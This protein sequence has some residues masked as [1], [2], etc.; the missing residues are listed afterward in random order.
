MTPVLSTSKTLKAYHGKPTLKQALLKELAAHRKADQLIKGTYWDGGKGC[1]VG[2]TID[3]LARIE[4]LADLERGNHALYER[5]LGIPEPLARIED[6]IFEGLPNALAQR[7]PEQFSAAIRPGADLSMVWVKF[8]HNLLTAKTGGVQRQIARRPALKP[9][10]DRVV[11][12]YARWIKGDKPPVA[13]WQQARSAAAADAADAAA[14]AAYA[15]ADAAAAAYAAAAAAD[16]AAAA[17]AVRSKER[18]RQANAL[19]RLLRAA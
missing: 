13:E 14:A 5:Y 15:A 10:V 16:A 8:V 18:V 12:L 2:C 4:G 3:S 1:A 17:A 7:W 6:G 9:S 19:L 11:A